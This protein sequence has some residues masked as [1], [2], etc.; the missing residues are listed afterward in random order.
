MKIL[1]LQNLTSILCTQITVIVHH[2][3]AAQRDSNRII[4]YSFNTTNFKNENVVFMKIYAQ[5]ENSVFHL[6]I[7]FKSTK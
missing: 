3:L 1:S 2:I 6:S 4:S 7:Y 5:L